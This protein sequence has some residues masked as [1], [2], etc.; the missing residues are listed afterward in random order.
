MRQD[1]P[2]GFTGKQEFIEGGWEGGL[3]G[4]FYFV[5]LEAEVGGCL[6]IGAGDLHVSKEDIAISVGEFGLDFIES[7]AFEDY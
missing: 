1:F 4:D 5:V 2:E 3:E 7:D 6:A